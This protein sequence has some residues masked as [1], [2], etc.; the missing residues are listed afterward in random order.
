MNTAIEQEAC[1]FREAEEG[2]LQTFSSIHF[3]CVGQGKGEKGKG[4]KV[5]EKR[6]VSSNR[7]W[8]WGYRTH[9]LGN[10]VSFSMQ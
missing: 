9:P 6:I 8:G 7:M 1:L 10:L 3:D 2:L 5:E 4:S